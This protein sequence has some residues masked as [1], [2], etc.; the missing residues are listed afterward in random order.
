MEDI[1][2]LLNP[3]NGKLQIRED[4]QYGE[5]YVEDLVI[6]PINNYKQSIDL[7]NAGL[8][9]RKIG[10]QVLDDIYVENESFVQQKSYYFHYL[11]F[12]K[13]ISYLVYVFHSFTY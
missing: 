8:K 6:V 7:I 5:T 13:D 4:Q 3:N 11:R 12:S 10:N 1:Y 2:D 9:F